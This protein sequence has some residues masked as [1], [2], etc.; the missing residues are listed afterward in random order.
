MSVGLYV[1]G[2]SKGR[3]CNNNGNCLVTLKYTHNI[4]YKSNDFYYKPHTTYGNSWSKSGVISR[5]IRR[6]T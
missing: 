1:L 6:R 3:G 5:A 4:V 2:G